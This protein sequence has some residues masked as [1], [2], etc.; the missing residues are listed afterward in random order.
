[1]VEQLAAPLVRTTAA[2]PVIVVPP[3]RK[4]TVPL[5]DTPETVAMKVTFAPA[6]DDPLPVTTTPDVD[7]VKDNERLWMVQVLA[8]AG[9]E[10]RKVL[11][12]LRKV[13]L[14]GADAV[15][16]A[17]AGRTNPGLSVTPLSPTPTLGVAEPVEVK[18]S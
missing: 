11:M 4:L 1:M 2:Q 6:V 12:P 8:S 7:R 17:L 15:K 3:L 13:T 10:R 14:I 5:G 9:R 16:V 18:R